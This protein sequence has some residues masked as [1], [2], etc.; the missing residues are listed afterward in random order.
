MPRE[1]ATRSDGYGAGVTFS[2]VARD[3]ATGELGVAVQSHAFSVGSLVPWLEPG[4]GAVA[5]QSLP[6]LD[7]GPLGLQA[8]REGASAQD[9][10]D[11]VAATDTAL[12]TRQVGMVAADGTAASHTGATCI[13]VAAHHVGDGLAVQGNILATDAVVPDMVAAWSDSAG[14]LPERL[15]AV[16]DAAQAAGGDARG[17]QSAALVTVGGQRTDR[18]WEQRGVQLRVEDHVRP[19]EELRRLLVLRRASDL[20]E[21]ADEQVADGDLATAVSTYTRAVE[22]APDVPELRFW[23]A[24]TLYT[25]GAH[26]DARSRFREL[27]TIE[28]HWRDVLARLDR[29]GLF[30]DDL[31]GLAH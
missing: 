27:V 22:L 29:S 10:L 28:P 3:P 25:A 7:F 26:D 20:L 5:T 9:A 14:P 11:R 17:Q 23:A 24:V 13:P 2:I 30:P 15:L 31:G 1:P 16:L 8:M 6:L 12:A 21:E 4:V 18:P 19:L